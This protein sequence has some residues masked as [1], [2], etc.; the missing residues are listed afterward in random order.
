M[1]SFAI[2]ILNINYICQLNGVEQV[3][4]RGLFAYNPGPPITRLTSKNPP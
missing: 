2:N 4:L 3:V 1:A